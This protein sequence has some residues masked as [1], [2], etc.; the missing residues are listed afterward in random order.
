[1]HV[2]RTLLFIIILGLALQV[3]LILIHYFV[4]PLPHALADAVQYED[5]GSA[6]AQFYFETGK[7]PPLLA[8]G[9]TL[10]ANIIGLVF[11]VF[12][13]VAFI[14]VILNLFLWV[15]LICLTYGI[16]ARLTKSTTAPYLAA[17]V[18]ALFPSLLTYSVVLQR[19]SFAIFFF[20]LSVYALIRWIEEGKGW[21]M[22]ASLA[23]LLC[24]AIFHFGVVVV[25]AVHLALFIFYGPHTQQ[26]V[27]FSRN[28]LLAPTIVKVMLVAAF[29]VSAALILVTNIPDRPLPE[30]LTQRLDEVVR[31]RATYLPDLRPS[32][33]A[34]I[35]LQTPVRVASFFFAPY[36]W[37]VEDPVDLF[38]VMIGLTYAVLIA[39]ALYSLRFMD[40][41]ERI[42]AVALLVIVAL[43]A[44]VFA[45]G[46][47]NYGTSLRHKSKIVWM[48]IALA[49]VSVCLSPRFES[50]R[51]R[52]CGT[53]RFGLAGLLARGR[54]YFSS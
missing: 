24:A 53:G 21:L 43:F 6:F 49:S 40:R 4:V 50:L 31:G 36:P 15:G 14:P 47:S 33:Y 22:V 13:T 28:Q 45:W 29:L 5:R 1:M 16:T 32:S 12:G 46:T 10:Y 48:L 23:S 38:G 30:V 42:R 52:V 37:D 8:A 54:K 44:I 17:L 20:A 3:G 9:S 7:L 35:V 34:D 25:G 19:D 26:W 41:N 39:L 51:A 11:V 18:T 2:T 27:M